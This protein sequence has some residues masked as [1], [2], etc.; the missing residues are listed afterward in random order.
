M[1]NSPIHPG[2]RVFILLFLVSILQ[3]GIFSRSTKTYAHPLSWIRMNPLAKRTEYNPVQFARL[4]NTQDTN[5]PTLLRYFTRLFGNDWLG[6]DWVYIGLSDYRYPALDKNGQ[7]LYVSD[8][9]TGVKTAQ[10]RYARFWTDPGPGL[11]KIGDT[12]WVWG[13]D[14]GA[15]T[16]YADSILVNLPV[17][18]APPAD[19]TTSGNILSVMGQT[20]SILDAGGLKYTIS[21]DPFTTFSFSAG[22]GLPRP[23]EGLWLNI[24]W[25][26]GSTGLLGRYNGF[27]GAYH[28]ILRLD[29]SRP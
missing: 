1:I 26:T 29:F 6:A 3:P 8:P 9:L 2:H 14:A 19:V 15:Y 24:S 27:H 28:G 7:Q 16:I 4:E 10:W 20:L 23:R 18:V 12:L 5:Q 21:V 11:L 17:R 25:L 22:E 13:F